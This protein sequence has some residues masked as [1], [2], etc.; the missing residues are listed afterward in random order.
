MRLKR[1]PLFLLLTAWFLTISMGVQS[2][3][4][5]AQRHQAELNALEQPFLI[6]QHKR[7][8]F[9]PLTYMSH[10]NEDVDIV[11]DEVG[12]THEEAKYQVS[13]KA[14]LYLPGESDNALE[15]LYAALTLLSYGQFYN[16]K[17][18]E[19]IRENNYAVEGY[20]S[21]R[22]DWSWKNHHVYSLDLGFNHSSNGK[23][24]IYSRSWNRIISTVTIDSGSWY[25]KLSLWL[26]LPEKQKSDPLQANGDDNP[27][28]THYMGYF[29]YTAGTKISHYS[30]EATFRNNL[31]VNSNKYYVELN[32]SVPINRRF[33]VL[34]QYV[35]GY[36]ESLIDYD[37]KMERIGIGFQFKY[38]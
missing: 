31:S 20:Y 13:L 2:S 19:P 12:L 25:S 5:L 7:N 33:D 35:N 26:R 18:S 1:I 10:L 16:S 14:P 24:D 37:F 8:Y 36:G 38:L 4:F 23:S 34:L 15:G 9:L 32:A 22:P 11:T 30:L 28:M 29:E 27:E 3:D 6:M 17:L 21:W